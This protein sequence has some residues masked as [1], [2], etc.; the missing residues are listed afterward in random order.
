MPCQVCQP[1]SSVQRA[2]SAITPEKEFYFYSLRCD[3]L[4]T[5]NEIS[6]TPST[7]R[8]KAQVTHN[9]RFQYKYCIV[10]HGHA[11]ILALYL[12]EMNAA[13]TYIGKI[14]FHAMSLYH[15][16]KQ[17]QNLYSTSPYT[18]FP[19]CTTFIIFLCHRRRP[20]RHHR[21]AASCVQ[22]LVST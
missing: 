14:I 20:R 18:V 13:Q 16:L 5:S 3:A 10:M 15:H 7:R 2:A 8:S 6:S 21:L 12:L 9:C 11:T 17:S 4:W 1:G 19:Q 22:S